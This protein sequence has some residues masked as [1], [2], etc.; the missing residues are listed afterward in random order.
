[1]EA[2]DLRTRPT[3]SEASAEDALSWDCERKNGEEGTN[4]FSISHFCFPPLRMETVDQGALHGS[5]FLVCPTPRSPMWR[6][7]RGY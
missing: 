3:L 4:A 2:E 5:R 7:M 6:R 1:M